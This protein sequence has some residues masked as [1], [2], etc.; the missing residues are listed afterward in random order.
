MADTPALLDAARTY[1]ASGA[2]RPLDAR[3]AALIALREGLE[4]ME[5][6]LLAALR[7]DLGKSEFEAW[8]SEI[9]LV[10]QEIALVLRRMRRWAAPRRVGGRWFHFPGR[11]AL[12]MEPRGAV[13]ILGPW[14]Y[15]VQLCLV[16]LVSAI[17]AGNA[18]VLKP[19]EVA[20]ATAAA[21]ERL[22]ARCFAPGH[23]QV[24]KGGPDVAVA[25]TALPFD[26]IFFTG[27]TETGRKV[28]EAAARNLATTT[29]ELGGANPCI[30]DASAEP[31]VT[32]RRIAWAK[33]LNAGQTCLAPNHVLVHES[34]AEALLGALRETVTRFY[35]PDGHGMQRVVNARHLARLKAMLARGRVA[36]GGAVDENALHIQPTI[37]LDPDPALLREEIFGP[38]LPVVSWRDRAEL[39]AGL[40]ALPQPLA[41]Y[42]HTRD[43][44][45]ADAVAEALPSGGFC[46]NEHL[47]HCTV[48][49][50]PFGGVGPSGQGRYHG[51]AGFEAFSNARA[52]FHQPAS[53]DPPLRYPPY[54]TPLSMIKRLMG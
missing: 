40:S 31:A 47:V 37:L 38:I 11:A 24:V 49:D 16:P 15:P 54:R 27:G 5:G 3:R 1:F 41:L 22:A 36:H 13:L 28:A 34:R 19:S 44:G 8:T 6:E 25:L 48:P 50:L 46:V 42:V 23:V 14:N 52:I 29:L 18:V 30:V 51:Q 4:A 33:F 35:G 39:L 17:A 9:M 10:R 43:R 2:T 7:T 20:P 12:R 32:A 45:F 21:L 53:I 26:H